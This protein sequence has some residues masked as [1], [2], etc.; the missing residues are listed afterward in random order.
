MTSLDIANHIINEYGNTVSLTN[1]KLNKLVYFAQVA[2]LKADG[3]PLFNDP[4]QAWDYG[5][6]EPMVYHTFRSYGSARIPMPTMPAALSTR[7]REIVA[8]TMTR[9]GNL[10]AFDLMRL[11]HRPG[12]AWSMRYKRGSNN[13]ISTDDICSSTDLTVFANTE[14][15]LAESV[16]NVE[17]AWPNALRLLENS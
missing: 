5:P 12:G 11:S 16:A 13:P 4:V 7:A 15:T 1:M 9:F 2:S 8:A 17:A 10:T 6:V 3:I 14:R